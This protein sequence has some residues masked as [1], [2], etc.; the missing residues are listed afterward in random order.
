M[1]YKTE[2]PFIPPKPKPP[3]PEER[4]YRISWTDIRHDYMYTY[5]TATS[6]NE[7]WEWFNDGR[8]DDVECND[9]D[10]VDTYDH[11]IEEA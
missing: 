10:I 9:S 5:I 8:Y 7:A 1:K 2:T 6:E 4:R 11:E 3:E